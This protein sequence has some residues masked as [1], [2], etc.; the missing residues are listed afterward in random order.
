MEKGMGKR[1]DT[2][3]LLPAPVLMQGGGGKKEAMRSGRQE[4]MS[5]NPCQGKAQA[6]QEGPRPAG[7]GR[8]SQGKG[9]LDPLCLDF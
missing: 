3:R 7:T 2:N 9:L 6:S 8:A 1:E 4:P 5:V